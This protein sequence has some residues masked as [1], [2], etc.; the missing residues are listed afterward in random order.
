MCLFPLVN[1]MLQTE[2]T[3]MKSPGRLVGTGA[4]VAGGGGG[5][6]MQLG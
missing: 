4:S 1:E 3:Y 6:G 5:G 2:E